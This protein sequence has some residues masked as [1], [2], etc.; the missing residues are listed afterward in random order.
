MS[1]CNLDPVPAAKIIPLRF[2]WEK[3]FLMAHDTL[4]NEKIHLIK[5]SQGAPWL[6]LFGIGPS[7]LPVKGIEQLQKLFNENTFWAKNRSTKKIKRMLANSDSVV[8]MWKNQ[9]LIG[10]GRATSD[11][12]FRCVLW[13]IVI[14]EDY[15]SNGLGKT[16]IESLLN[17]KEIRGVEKIYLMTTN[18]KDFYK[19][20]NFIEV[21]NQFLLILSTRE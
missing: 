10:F 17:S 14:S 6:R 8:S 18:C 20:S 2:I 4:L 13:D 3:T 21:E 16:L 11:K 5:H 19:S 12:S 1:G 9:T 15:Q 7:F